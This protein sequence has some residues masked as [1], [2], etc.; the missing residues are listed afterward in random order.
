MA[1]VAQTPA[2]SQP[3]ATGDHIAV[4]VEPN[5][6]GRTFWLLRRSFIVAAEDNLYGIAKG[7]AYSGLLSLFPILTTFAAILIQIRA[8]SVVH[9]ISRVTLAVV[10]PG[11]EELI[12]SRFED[13]GNR[14]IGLLI[15][16]TVLALWAASGA[17]M[18]LI[19]GFQA[20]YRIPTERSMLKQRAM[21]VFLVLIVAIPFV[22]ASL[23]V[24][25]GNRWETDV[26]H[27][28]RLSES[29]EIATLPIIILG[30][31]LRYVL[32]FLTTVLVTGLLYYFGPNHRPEQRFTKSATRSRFLRVWPGAFVAAVLWFVATAGFA[33]YVKNL[34]RYN[35]VYGALGAG[36]ILLV[37]MYLLAVITLVGCEFN[38]ER[39]RSQSLLSLY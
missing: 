18:S 12:R 1:H 34:A 23:L 20:A 19:E 11:T 36:I 8:D 33:W 27:L 22:G 35:V 14:P 29:D 7:A 24:L 4:V 3:A 25:F 31:I 21:A 30:R 13:E 6:F 26:I 5:W 38:A 39:E 15:A 9:L 32:A 37:W 10:P 17:M 16:A 2:Q 28:F